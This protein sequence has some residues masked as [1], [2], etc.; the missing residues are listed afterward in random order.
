MRAKTDG[1]L[2]DLDHFKL[3][4]WFFETSELLKVNSLMSPGEK[5][6]FFM[7]IRKIDWADEALKFHYGVVRYFLFQDAQPHDSNM[8]QIVKINQIQYGH[9]IMV[10]MK[11]Y[12]TLKEKNLSDLFPAVLDGQKYQK[13]IAQVLKNQQKNKALVL[14]TS[15]NV[16]Q[17]DQA[18]AEAQ[19]L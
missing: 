12:P 18:S 19:L 4:E 16:I 11:S 2:D 13:F 14:P 10:A 8:R 9:D 1:S 7:D 17:L 3:N 5:D 6:E 15:G